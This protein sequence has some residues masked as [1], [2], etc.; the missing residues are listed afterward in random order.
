MIALVI[1]FGGYNVIYDYRPSWSDCEEA[2]DLLKKA[3]VEATCH[4]I[5][6]EERR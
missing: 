5:P 2:M 6:E 3:H 1:W 4:L